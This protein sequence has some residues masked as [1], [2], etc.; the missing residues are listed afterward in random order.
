MGIIHV[1]LAHC[2]SCG[3]EFKGFCAIS[4]YERTFARDISF[5]R[6]GTLVCFKKL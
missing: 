4:S 2:D 5:A 3:C 1:G 6:V